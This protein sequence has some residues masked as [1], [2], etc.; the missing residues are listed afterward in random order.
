VRPITLL[1]FAGLLLLTTACADKT[2]VKIDHD[3]LPPAVTNTSYFSLHAKGVNKKGSPI[4]GL[5]MTYSGS[6][7]D[8]LEATAD[9]HLRCA[10]TGDATLT[11]A[12]AGF[13]QP[14]PLN[15]RIPTEISVPSELRLVLKDPA[16]VFP[17]RVLG[18]GSQPLADV[19]AQLTSSDS[20]IFSVEEDKLKPVAVGK[21][22]LKSSLGGIS[23]MTQV[24]VVDRVVS[25]AL[26]LRDGANR[27][28][29]LQ[30]ANYEVN[31]E[32]KVDERLKQ[33]VTVSWNGAGCDNQL[34][35]ASHHF[36][37]RV[38]DPATLTVTNPKLMGVGATVQGTV[39]VFRIPD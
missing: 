13:S 9:G 3:P 24:E 20:T 2:P 32:L 14:V 33:G 11:L 23:S 27:S 6:P 37:C 26:T 18:E 29:T 28:F 36:K 21:G 12:V 5:A 10:K 8:V 30:P 39:Q 25:E 17:A 34:E 16:T 15:C 1:S 7:A 4:E 22:N 31:V 38:A 35:A 19:K